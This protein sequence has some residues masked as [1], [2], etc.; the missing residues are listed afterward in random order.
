M[1]DNVPL[2]EYTSLFIHSP[3][4]GYLGCFHLSAIVSSAAENICLQVFELEHM[5]TNAFFFFSWSSNFFLHNT[6]LFICFLLEAGMGVPLLCWCPKQSSACPL[7][8][9]HLFSVLV[10]L[11]NLFPSFP[12]S[13]FPAHICMCN[14]LEFILAS[15]FPP[16]YRGVWVCVLIS[17]I[18]EYV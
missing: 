5:N 10:P 16:S 3:V 15:G 12:S 2:C 1:M 4:D 14:S 13:R 18:N 7:A 6:G 11:D 9:F 8:M 17:T